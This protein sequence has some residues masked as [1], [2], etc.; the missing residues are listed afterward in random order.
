MQFAHEPMRPPRRET[1]GEQVFYRRWQ[2]LMATRPYEDPDLAD[3]TWLDVILYDLFETVTQR[4]AVVAASLVVWLGTNCGL[5]LIRLA[6]DEQR[7]NPF[8]CASISWVKAWAA[9]NRRLRGVNHAVRILEHLLA[10]AQSI[11]TDGALKVFPDLSAEDYEVAEHLCAWF[12]THRGTEFVREAE[13]EIAALKAAAYFKC[14]R[15]EPAL[16]VHGG[17]AVWNTPDHSRDREMLCVGGMQLGGW[18]PLGD[19]QIKGFLNRLAAPQ[20]QR[21]F[22]DLGEAKAWVE[23]GATSMLA[24][25]GPGAGQVAQAV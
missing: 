22:V 23:S 10:P 9:A 17:V 14:G 24:A 16:N 11:A 5:D 8:G 20:S 25:L 2:A 13:A 1:L 18:E 19:G 21:V 6:A 15:I 12:G 4:H 3:R 7:R